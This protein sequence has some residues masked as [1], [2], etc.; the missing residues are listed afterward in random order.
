M[1]SGA[2][3]RDD[4]ALK[5]CFE[6]KGPRLEEIQPIHRIEETVDPGLVEVLC[7]LDAI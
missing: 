5:A 7:N 3:N 1:P 2:I 4:P 6:A